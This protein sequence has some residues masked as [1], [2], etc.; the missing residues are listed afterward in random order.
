MGQP[1]TDAMVKP[2]IYD[3]WGKP[4][5]LAGWTRR[6]DDVPDICRSSRSQPYGWHAVVSIGLLG[7]K[8]SPCGSGADRY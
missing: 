8:Q 6:S 1:H 5:D 7:L 2:A 4:N 3:E